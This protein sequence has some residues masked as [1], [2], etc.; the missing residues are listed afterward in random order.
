MRRYLSVLLAAAGLLLAPAAGHGT[1]R[2][3]PV[4]L[5]LAGPAPV[6]R[7]GEPATLGLELAAASDVTVSDLTVESASLARPL[8]RRAAPMRAAASSPLRFEVAL[9]PGERP[10]PLV[11]RYQVDGQ[12]FEQTIDLTSRMESEIER[13]SRLTQVEAA[14]LTRAPDARLLA[15]ADSVRRARAEQGA[16]VDLIFF[17]G[18]LVYRRNDGM[19]IGAMGVRVSLMDADSW[20]DPDD[21]L[22]ETFTDYEGDFHYFGVWDPIT[23]NRPDVYIKFETDHPWVKVQ[24]GFFEIE[25]SWSGSTYND[26]PEGVSLD[27][28]TVTPSDESQHPAL[29][30]ATD[31]ARDHLWYDEHGYF[32][33]QIDVHWPDGASGAYYDTF[34]NE[35]HVSSGSSWNEATH[36][37]EYGHYWVDTFASFEDP[38]YCNGICDSDGCGHCTWCAETDHDALNEGWPNWIAHVQTSSYAA[39]YGLASGW[40]RD[41][42]SIRTCSDGMFGDPERTEGF[43]G[44]VLQDIWDSGPGSDDVDPNGL[45]SRDRLAL[46]TDEIFTVMDVDQP[47]RARQF[48]TRFRDRY[49]QYRE[50]LW[51]TARN[52][53]W[54]LD[55]TG[56]GVAADLR[57]TSHPVNTPTG[58]LV[59]TL[60]WTEPADDWSGVNGYSVVLASSPV[61]PDDVQDHPNLALYV[62]NTL[63]PGTYYFTLRAIDRLGRASPGYATAGPFIVT[64]PTPADLAPYPLAGWPRPL[65]ARS[66]NN[67]TPTFAPDPTAI[68]PGNAAGTWLNLGGRN[69]GQQSY[70]MGSR[71]LFYVDGVPWFPG[72]NIGSVDPGATFSIVNQGPLTVRGGRHM[73]GT[74][75]DAFNQWFESD[76]DNNYWAHPWV[77]SPL[78]L[79]AGTPVRR[80]PPPQPT[81]GWSS[82][83][84]FSPLFYNCDGFRFTSSGWW[85]AVW[86]AGD[87][88]T[89]DY[90]CR[91]HFATSSPDTGFDLIRAWSSAPEGYLDA[92]LVNRN[93]LGSLAWD[94]AVINDQTTTNDGQP[95]APFVVKH[96]TSAGFPFGDTL[97]VSFPDSEYV[98]LR[99]VY[100]PA[101]GPVSITVEADPALGPVRATWLDRTFTRGALSSYVPTS[102]W[103][104]P[105][106]RVSFDATVTAAGYHCVVLHRD[107][108]DGRG[109]RSL[110]LGVGTTP[111]DAVPWTQA[112]WHGPIVPRPAADGTPGSTPM[113]DTLDGGVPS[114]YLNLAFRNESPTPT[115]G[116]VWLDVL[117]DGGVLAQSAYGLPAFGQ[118][119]SNW[120][121]Q[122]TVP[123]G[124]HMLGVIY[125]PANLMP[126]KSDGNNAW[127]EQWVWSPVPLAL[128][129]GVTRPAPPDPVGGFAEF[130]GVG[131]LYYNSLGFRTPAFSGFTGRWAGVGL[132]PAASTDCDLRL[133]ELQ[134]GAR[135]ALGANLGVSSWGP[136]ESDYVVV[137]FGATSYRRFDVSVIRGDE[138]A[139]G[140]FDLEATG[141]S[142][143][144]AAPITLGDYTLEADDILHVHPLLLPAGNTRVRLENVSGALDW[145]VSVHADQ[146]AIQSKAEALN[147]AWLQGPGQGEEC[148]VALPSP[149]TVAVVA[150][151][152]GSADRNAG[153]GYRIVVEQVTVG[154]G[155]A[156]LPDRTRL[157]LARPS[158]FRSG[159]T[160][161]FDLASPSPV[162][163]EIFDL[164]GARVRTLAEG[165][166]P[167]GRHQLAWRGDDD[168][169]RP[170]AAGVYLARLVAGS[171]RGHQKLVKVD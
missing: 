154:A 6:L 64:Q 139:A 104:W 3:D 117:L 140:A 96:V 42:E 95:Q 12:P 88:D 23:E 129:A 30:I 21:E 50:L 47:T 121:V 1:I 149:D 109:P 63:A 162:R 26:I 9:L 98:L 168:G 93:T 99:E 169:G 35:I 119:A 144:V 11:V 125:D 142:P 112:G 73:I 101:P 52:S 160:L 136:D 111:P 56:P 94:V 62:S 70:L 108:K 163:L 39:T 123:A 57:S 141:S 165:M 32:L 60:A 27:I 2:R 147:A 53:R 170:L 83:R 66:S 18:R 114:T 118:L 37:H 159:T 130:A 48:L 65:V 157:Q 89:N 161:A 29:H 61:P 13:S 43:I 44:A 5:R 79:T 78:A 133:H 120:T 158:P 137:N 71:T 97:A 40:T 124:R 10:D 171:Y 153:G 156:G 134:P 49:P 128:N 166:L 45:A 106:G 127:A 113:P 150:W 76:E 33:G 51:E 84:D 17:S 7:P 100:V 67:S 81:A 59:I 14:S 20:P 46:G 72:V 110:T 25:Y 167:A 58:N 24:R 8:D 145:G 148:S 126:E 92:V 4:K 77:W 135:D 34:W 90:D 54:E 68:L 138:G 87:A 31:I 55:E 102:G 19:E 74:I 107:P 131:P 15:L 164:R 105:S 69:E 155:Q 132:L 36:A 38:D 16:S 146:P 85:N 91:L 151:K 86:V 80:Q 115:D 75:L 28:G 103:T 22:G 122:Y 82:V 41:Q 116:L 143:L 152:R